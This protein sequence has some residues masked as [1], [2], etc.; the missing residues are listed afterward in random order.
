MRRL[1]AFG[2]AVLVVACGDTVHRP[3][4]AGAP[5]P[6]VPSP[7]APVPTAR[8][9]A[10]AL[11]ALEAAGLSPVEMT[12][13]AVEGHAPLPTYGARV[14][15]LSDRPVRR[16]V[17][18]VV[19][20]DAAG[21]ALPGENHDVAFGSPLKAIDPG[22]TLQTSFLSR[23]ERAPSVRLVA[24]VV[25]FLEAGTGA[26]PVPVEWTNPRYA[27]ELARASGTP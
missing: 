15:N 7:P 4:P 16:V 18:T 23:V 5:Q 25:T 27:E 12:A 13:A 1:P 20:L 22:V 3:I 9:T 17:A 8:P 19:Y 26:E 11:A 6:R 10:A 2:L 21:R 14:K 24:R